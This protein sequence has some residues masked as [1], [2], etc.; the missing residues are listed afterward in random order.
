MSILH[1]FIPNAILIQ[2]GPLTIYYYGILI[3]SGILISTII[4]LKLAQRYAVDK[5]KLIDLLF[6][7]LIF[8]LAGGRFYHVMLEFPYYLAHPLD[9]FKVWQGGLAI[10]GGIIAGLSALYIFSKK[11]QINFWLLS[12]LIVPG[13]A[14]AQAIGRVGNYFN[15]EL[16]GLPTFLP[17]GIPIEI[18]NRVAPYFNSEYYHPTFLYESIGNL[19]IFILLMFFHSYIIKHKIQKKTDNKIFI[20]LSLS[21]LILYSL[22]RFGLEF[23]RIDPTPEFLFFRFPQI[24]S[25]III[26]IS[27]Y[28]LYVI[29]K[30]KNRT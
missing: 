13:L 15:Q 6:W 30:E 16:F 17:W 27:V 20:V 7:L 9:I 18:Q 24:V 10:H 29:K 23:I 11:N 22:L 12:A 19:L 1:T 2:I 8:G 5:N 25:L 21:Y 26:F 3:V 4:V 28:Y 14:L